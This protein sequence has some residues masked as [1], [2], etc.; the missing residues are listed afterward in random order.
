MAIW[1]FLCKTEFYSIEWALKSAFSRVAYVNKGLEHGL[2]Y[3]NTQN[4]SVGI[5]V[6][7]NNSL[8]TYNVIKFSLKLY[9]E[10]MVMMKIMFWLLK[11]INQYVVY[12][13]LY[14]WHFIELHREGIRN[15]SSFHWQVK[16]MKQR[17]TMVYYNFPKLML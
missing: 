15:N 4:E 10:W 17:Q 1:L 7:E 6:I 11:E 8:N 3:T 13:M 16:I 5:F 14:I 12:S 2:L 9:M